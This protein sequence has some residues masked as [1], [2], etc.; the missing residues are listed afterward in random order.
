MNS[1]I[2]DI[3]LSY[4]M[5]KKELEFNSFFNNQKMYDLMNVKL[6]CYEL[7]YHCLCH[8]VITDEIIQTKHD[9]IKFTARSIFHWINRGIIIF[10]TA[11]NSSLKRIFKKN[12][13]TDVDILFISKDRFVK[14]NSEMGSS[15]SDSLFFNIIQKISNSNLTL[16]QA[17][18]NTTNP[19]N[20][21]NINAYNLFKYVYLFDVI[22]SIFK[23]LI[24]L[25]LWNYKYKSISFSKNRD[26]VSNISFAL[27]MESFFTFKT[28]FYYYIIDYAFYHIILQLNP[29]IIVSNDDV[30]MLK[31]KIKNSTF[32]FIVMQYGWVAPEYEYYRKLFINKFGNESIKSDYFICT[33]E[34]HKK[35]KEFSSTSKNIIISGQSRYDTLAHPT[36]IYNKQKIFKKL[37]LDL[38]K[39]MILW[40]TSTHSLLPHE[41]LES[42]DA[43]YSTM[44]SFEDAQLVIKLHPTEDQNA[45]L[46]RKN[47][48]YHPIIA[49][50]ETDTYA[51]LFACDLMITKSSTTALEA[52][53]LNKP[54]VILNL[55]GEPD[56]IDYVKEG[57]A[58]GVYDKKDL[59]V[60]I[61]EILYNEKF[62]IVNRDDYIEKNLYLIDGKASERALNII[63]NAYNDK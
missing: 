27:K 15:S 56:K 45:P 21:I 63:I 43:I 42:I 50:K 36:D 54:I 38:N 28:I 59:K 51:L 39:K 37:G 4:E 49:N 40:M 52:I 14:I 46:Y 31:P 17:L 25:I 12:N 10:L 29:Q 9:P 23:T 30:M 16:K 41:N 8:I 5:K 48:T 60:V 35:L 34:Y 57:V 20:D 11:I 33:G 19:P 58:I 22:N 1:N 44:L 53:I 7:W 47:N 3:F 55:S 18:V 13:I 26:N 62:L 24:I 32:K 61:K 6:C 2:D